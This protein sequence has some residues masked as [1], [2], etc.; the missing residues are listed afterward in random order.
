MYIIIRL[1]YAYATEAK[2]V[3][4]SNQSFTLI[5]LYEN[6]V[7][8]QINNSA[9]Y[10]FLDESTER[11]L[12]RPEGYSSLLSDNF[13]KIKFR[14]PPSFSSSVKFFKLFG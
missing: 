1:M 12:P 5:S 4:F 2:T 14:S 7:G 3:T 13:I 11:H 9:N 8:P 6:V 10:V